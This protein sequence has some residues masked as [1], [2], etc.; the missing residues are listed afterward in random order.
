MWHF[1]LFALFVLRYV[2]LLGTTIPYLLSRA[3]PRPKS[4]TY[5]PSDVTAIVP[6]VDPFSPVLLK[7]LISILATNP[8]RILIVTVGLGNLRKAQSLI[9]YLEHYGTN[10]TTLMRCLQVPEANR[11][12]QIVHG[13][14]HVKTSI[15]A[16]CQ[17][18][19]VL[20]PRFLL[21]M[22][23]PFEDPACGAVGPT[24]RVHRTTQSA[25]WSP[26]DVFKYLAYVH[27]SL[28]N[29]IDGVVH[30]LSGY[31]LV[32]RTSILQDAKYQTEYLNERNPGPVDDGCFLTRYLLAHNWKIAIQQAEDATLEITVDSNPQCSSQALRCTRTHW[33]NT[34]LCAQTRRRHLWSRYAILVSYF[35]Q[36]G[37]LY[38][39]L[40][41]Y[42][43]WKWQQDFVKLDRL[44]FGIL[45]ARCVEMSGLA[46]ACFSVL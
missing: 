40:L 1:L 6:T 28:K 23:A 31:S 7:T 22:L 13:V 14:K 5:I 27:I 8:H 39:M 17:D 44:A 11:R 16:L 21:H 30:C 34:L 36:F 29:R 18:D 19:V 3:T 42:V 24:Q 46:F 41:V 33:R 4:P 32:V 38:G 43:F 12:A 35:F 37:L 25:Q 10:T 26:K 20:P 9:A 45:A 15:V 2:R